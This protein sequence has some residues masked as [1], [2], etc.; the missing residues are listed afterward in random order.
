MKDSIVGKTYTHKT[1]PFTEKVVAVNY[2]YNTATLKNTKTN[3]Y[4]T[5]KLNKF[6]EE[7]GKERVE[8]TEGEKNSERD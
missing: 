8:L 4:T 6:K 2:R 3:Q 7:I 1:L 5:H